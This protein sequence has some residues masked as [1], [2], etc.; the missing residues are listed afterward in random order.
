LHVFSYC[1][2]SKCEKLS[3]SYVAAKVG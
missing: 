1:Q 2:P 3:R